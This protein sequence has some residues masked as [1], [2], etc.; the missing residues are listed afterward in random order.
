VPRRTCLLVRY[1]DSRF[2]SSLLPVAAPGGPWSRR[3]ELHLPDPV[4]RHL[5]LLA[6]R[7]DQPGEPAGGPAS[8]ADLVGLADAV[9]LVTDGRAPVQ[10]TEVDLL[11]AATLR[12]RPIF[13]AVAQADQ[14]VNWPDV[15]R[16]NQEIL[17]RQ[18]PPMA[19][20]PWYALGPASSPIGDLRRM[21]IDWAGQQPG[22][23]A[24]LIRIAAHPRPGSGRAA[25][26][27]TVLTG[28]LDRA[29]DGVA[30]EAI[31]QLTEVRV[32]CLTA[33]EVRIE[34]DRRLQACSVALTLHLRGAAARVLQTVLPEVLL[35]PAGADPAGADPA[36]AGV[37]G[38]DPA[39]SSRPVAAGAPPTG[40]LIDCPVERML[41][42]VRRQIADEEVGDSEC[43]RAVLVTTNGD[44]AKVSL[45]RPLPGLTAHAYDPAGAV[46]PP[47]GIGLTAS[48]LPP[49]QEPDP[50]EPDLHWAT[51][52]VEAVGEALSGELD[53]Q[54]D[55]LGRVVAD[56]IA[57]G[58]RRGV[59][60]V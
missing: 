25:P 37:A 38:V 17:A 39:G 59:L 4:L 36:G 43:Y 40:S 46:L 6:A 33:P 26:W 35:D 49:C 23:G 30:A 56:L 11:R 12:Q 52:V 5:C 45:P 60:L 14:A 44:V 24:A 22:G 57:D 50:G 8:P 54:L 7:A 21:L 16:A 29:R 41:A 18:L 31:R 9:V 51:R 3:V 58:C 42:A 48:C 19:F 1:G 28:A 27:R 20:E 15:V 34:L 55:Q 53:R 32:G 47:L 2:D 10:R 13:F